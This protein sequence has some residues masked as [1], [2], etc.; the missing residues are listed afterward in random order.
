MFSSKWQRSHLEYLLC[1]C[2]R[3]PACTHF[4]AHGLTTRIKFSTTP[5]GRIRNCSRKNSQG[6]NGSK[7]YVALIFGW[8]L[9]TLLLKLSLLIW[10]GLSFHL[11][12]LWVQCCY[13]EIE[14]QNYAWGFVIYKCYKR[15]R[16]ST[17]VNVCSSYKVSLWKAEPT[18]KTGVWGPILPG[19]TLH[20]CLPGKVPWQRGFSS[21]LSCWPNF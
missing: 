16:C 9:A 19:S 13:L 8:I 4:H 15:E 5:I 6:L 1:S 7:Q 20:F 11:F 17:L 10:V 3:V 14:T 2:P 12:S 21:S 18:R